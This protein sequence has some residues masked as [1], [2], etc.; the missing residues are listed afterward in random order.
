MGCNTEKAAQLSLVRGP[1]VA[2]SK[3]T[4]GELR[5]NSYTYQ[6]MAVMLPSDN[7]SAPAVSPRM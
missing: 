3:C 7:V 1:Y 5:L 4:T 2:V 6:A